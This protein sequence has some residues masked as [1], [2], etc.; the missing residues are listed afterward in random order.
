MI[1]IIGY[2][3]VIAKIFGLKM[4]PAM[5][6]ACFISSSK[7][8]VNYVSVTFFEGNFDEKWLRKTCREWYLKTFQK[9]S[10]KVVMKLGDLYY[11]QMPQEEAY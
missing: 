6:Q 8:N 4:M 11:K 1:G 10:Y 9:Y 2:Q 3:F 7:S 5:D